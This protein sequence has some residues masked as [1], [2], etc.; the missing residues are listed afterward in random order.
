MQSKY[1]KRLRDKLGAGTSAMVVERSEPPPPAQRGVGRGSS[2]SVGDAA[3]LMSARG[4]VN[5]RASE[6]RYVNV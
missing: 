4:A 6:D 1:M 2:K 5:K 3:L